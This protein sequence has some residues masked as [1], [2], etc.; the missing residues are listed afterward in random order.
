MA[1]MA[2]LRSK[3]NQIR[4]RQEKEKEHPPPYS[5]R[6]NI[7][8]SSL[9]EK[10]NEIRKNS[11]VSPDHRAGDTGRSEEANQVRFETKVF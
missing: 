10:I 5:P 3:I 11:G 9:K 8:I 6:S 7:N 4:S 2:T 1:G